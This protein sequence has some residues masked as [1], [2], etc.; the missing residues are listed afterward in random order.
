MCTGSSARAVSNLNYRG[1]SPT[2]PFKAFLETGFFS[3]A[4]AVLELRLRDLSACVSWVLG[5]NVCTITAQLH[6]LFWANFAMAFFNG[7]IIFSIFHSV[8]TLFSIMAK[9]YNILGSVEVMLVAEVGSWLLISSSL[10]C[11][12]VICVSSWKKHLLKSL[13]HCLIHLLFYS[14]LFRCFLPSLW[15]PCLWTSSFAA[16]ILW[17]LKL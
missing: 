16:L 17:S 4:L 10:P 1:G 2:P 9:P 13:V 8:Q 7:C 15:R 11:F 5:L 6:L 12:L 14:A 3:V